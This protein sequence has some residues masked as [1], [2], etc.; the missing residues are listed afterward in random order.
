MEDSIA[1][2]RYQNGLPKRS[3]SKA[4]STACSAGT[5]ISN[6]NRDKRP[7][8]FNNTKAFTLGIGAIQPRLPA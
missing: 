5:Y 2:G 3:Q 6:I 8:M 7:T 4:K 1:T